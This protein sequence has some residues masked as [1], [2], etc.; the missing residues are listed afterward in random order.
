MIERVVEEGIATLRLAHGKASALD[1]ELLEA[2]GETL[3]E[4]ERSEARAVILTGTGSIFSAGVDLFRIVNEGGPYVA[5]FL[6]ALGEAVTRLFTFGRPVVAAVNG[7]AI[8][9]GCVLA[10]AADY[11]IMAAGQGRIGV[12]ELLVGVPFP[13]AAL[14]AVRYTAAP[15]RLQALLFTGATLAPEAAV[16]A[17]LVDEVAEPDALLARA[18]EVARGL[19][20]L[21]TATFALTKQQLRQ[22]ALIRMR[23]IEAAS[24]EEVLAIWSSEATR[25]RIRNYLERTVGRAK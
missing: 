23:E 15:H 1:V 6:P 12:P 20:A 17:G 22:P 5:R 9:G 18:H 24:S 11:T 7:H 25:E 3:D 19:A 10:A 8:A 16:E 21:P 4:V 14:E 13:A 2:L